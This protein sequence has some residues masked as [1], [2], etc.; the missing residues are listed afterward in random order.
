[1]C[2]LS[3]GGHGGTCKEIASLAA[4]RLDAPQNA[5]V[6]AWHLVFKTRRAQRIGYD[7]LMVWEGLISLSRLLEGQGRSEGDGASRP[8]SVPLA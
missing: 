5:V 2:G 4:D 8:A 6:R 7:C 1:M 3:V